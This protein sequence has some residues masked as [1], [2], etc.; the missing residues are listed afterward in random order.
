[1]RVLCKKNKLNINVIYNSIIFYC[2]KIWCL[3]LNIVKTIINY[4]EN[5]IHKIPIIFVYYEIY[6][7][8]FLIVTH[9]ILYK[10]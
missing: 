1:M 5:T 7:L 3:D 2:W 8:C 6:I 9:A 4:T 10:N